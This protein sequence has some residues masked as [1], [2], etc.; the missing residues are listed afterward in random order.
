[1]SIQ[2]ARVI[3]IQARQPSPRPPA[4]PR[5]DSFELVGV[6]VQPPGESVESLLGQALAAQRE[7]RLN[8]AITFCRRAADSAPNLWQPLYNLALCLE[9]A[10]RPE[11]AI[12]TLRGACAV[13]PG[14]AAPALRL[15]QLLESAGND[16]EA[17]LWLARATFSNPADCHAWLRL[18]LLHL[19]RGDFEHAASCLESAVDE[20][21]AAASAAYHLGLCRLAQGDPAG[22]R[23]WLERA[24]EQRPGVARRPSRPGRGGTG[25]GQPGRCRSRRR[26]AA[27]G[28][29]TGDALAASGPGLPGPR[30]AG[31]G[32][33]ALPE[34]RGSR[35]GIRARLL[36][37]T[38]RSL[39]PRKPAK[40]VA[41]PTPDKQRRLKTVD[42]L[43]S[44][45]GICS[46]SEAR[47]LIV[48][49]HLKVN[50]APVRDPEQW[51]D[52]KRDKLLLDGRPL[53]A[54]KRI[55]ILL[56]K[57]KG[58][59]TTYKDPDGRPTVY[60]LLQ[61][62]DQWVFPVGRLDQDTSG[63]LLLT[64]DT[65][66][67]ELVTNPD[68]HVPKTYLVKTST[69]LS[70]EQ[71]DR[72]RNGLELKDGPT[73]PA[74]VQRI[75]DS[76]TRTFL[77]ITI[78]EGRNRQ[79]RRMIEALDSKAAKL[80]RV[81]LGPLRIHELPIGHWRPLLSEELRLLRRAAG[82]GQTGRKPEPAKS[83][84]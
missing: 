71:L 46:R 82:T 37:G 57:P 23:Q 69:L 78:T 5:S 38:I 66:L 84:E 6:A 54:E 41:A 63:L 56:Y 27:R 22:A 65:D 29:R 51:V 67:A 30:T 34:G 58:Y 83:G 42:R 3:P 45:A 28:R 17:A 7:G 9:S 61:N 19:R 68:H 12:T 31:A 76:A 33:P 36:H 2:T 52:P 47:E 77:E 26:P 11:E 79:V 4:A 21:S 48:R 70:D 25:R 24:A 16:A 49:G 44:K 73:R 39:K 8:Q 14:E 81:A 13:A 10:G 72:L 59:L 32:A 60:D 75:R 40:P 18:G 80:V 35:A 62:I 53:R 43:L 50:G 15:G 55:Y 1:M 64:N 74:K 20:V